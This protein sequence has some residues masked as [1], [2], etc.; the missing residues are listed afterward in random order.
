MKKLLGFFINHVFVGV[1]Q[2]G[3][4]PPK[5]ALGI[6]S[7]ILYLLKGYKLRILSLTYISVLRSYFQERQKK[8]SILIILSV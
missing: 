8:D 5:H 2:Y 7:S 6:L 3:F 1:F 4:G